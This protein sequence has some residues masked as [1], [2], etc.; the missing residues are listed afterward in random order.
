MFEVGR[1]YRRQELHQQ[2][3]GQR[4]GGI[5][6]PAGQPWV[7][8]ISGEEGS[9]FGYD[10]ERLP[11]GTLLYFGEGQVGPQS[12]TR[13]NAAIQDH[14]DA[15]EDLYLF[16]KVR[17]GYVR[18]VGQY[19]YVGHE[20]RDGVRDRNGD[21]RTA[22]VFQLVPH[23]QLVQDE[24]DGN[25]EVEGVAP[26][27]LEALRKAALEGASGEV[28]P[29]E[30]RRRIWRRSRAVRRYV[31]QRAGSKCEG[32]EQDAPFL[33]PTGQ[34]YLEPHHT[35]RISDSGPDHP[36]WVISLCPTCHR[37]VHHGA[38][39]NGYNKTLQAK[40]ALLEGEAT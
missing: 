8:L 25:D 19:I 17:D 20:L 34:P 35:R 28:E 15:G 18:Y 33:R 6:T 31:L 37:R 7:M 40:L 10:D 39:G 4:Y 9:A 2:Y 11:D 1:V 21:A 3:G 29:A 14:A 13:G 30:G 22:I 5:S 32:C 26:D 24:L 27:D 38:D 12:F 36:R 16:Q 23:E